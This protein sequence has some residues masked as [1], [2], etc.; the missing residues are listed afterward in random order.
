[1]KIFC[2]IDFYDKTNKTIIQTIILYE[3]FKFFM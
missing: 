2:E 1:M 3:N